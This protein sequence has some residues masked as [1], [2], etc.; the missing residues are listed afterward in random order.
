MP[1][2]GQPQ[3][4]DRWCRPFASKRRYRKG[5]RPMIR[6]TSLR[7]GALALALAMGLPQAVFSANT[8]SPQSVNLKI[9]ELWISPN[10]DCTELT[11]IYNNPSASYQNMVT[12][13]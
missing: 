4:H 5:G 2:E 10:A 11:R 13:P 12:G 8:G 9:Y 1:Q 7:L 6:S 3:R